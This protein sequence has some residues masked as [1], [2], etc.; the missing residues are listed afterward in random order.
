MRHVDIVGDEKSK[1]AACKADYNCNQTLRHFGFLHIHIPTT[2][3]WLFQLGVTVLAVVSAF[4]GKNLP[5]NNLV[6]SSEPLICGTIYEWV[7]GATQ[8]N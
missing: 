1:P 8:V 6:L 3:L 7:Y 5:Q 2:F 4:K